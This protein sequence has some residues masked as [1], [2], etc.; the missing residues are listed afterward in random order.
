MTQEL[1]FS[2]PVCEQPQ[3]DQPQG[4]TAVAVSG[5]RIAELYRSFKRLR[6]L[7]QHLHDHSPSSPLPA[8]VKIDNITID[9]RVNGIQQHLNIR[10]VSYIGDIAQLL[11]RETEQLVEDIRLE[12]VN[13]QVAAAAIE[14]VCKR[15]QYLSRAQT[16]GGPV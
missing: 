8:H 15:A 5:A 11:A 7:T 10:D 4:E 2:A 6:G 13:A 9:Y 16:A 12:C 1:S 14:E 3:I